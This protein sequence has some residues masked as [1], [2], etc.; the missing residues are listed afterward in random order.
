MITFPNNKRGAK[1]RPDE[2]ED[3]SENEQTMTRGIIIPDAPELSVIF[4]CFI[5]FY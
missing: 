1:I 5:I 2:D 3:D 4:I